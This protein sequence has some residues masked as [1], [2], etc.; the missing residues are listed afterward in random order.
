MSLIPLVAHGH[1]VPYG[2][3]RYDSGDYQHRYG[4]RVRLP[5]WIRFGRGYLP[6]SDEYRRGWWTGCVVVRFK[7]VARGFEFRMMFGEVPA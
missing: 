4:V 5:L 1:I 6:E 2:V 7:R 3:S